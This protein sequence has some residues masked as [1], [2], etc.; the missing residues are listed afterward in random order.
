MVSF[1]QSSGFPEPFTMSVLAKGSLF[2]T[3]PTVMDYTRTR[4]ELLTCAG[5]VFSAL[6][7]GIIKVRVN[8]TYPFSATAQAQKDLQERR[9]TGSTVLIVDS[10]A[11][12]AAKV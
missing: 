6:A 7:G 10:T 2:L 8:Q 12:D 3:R 9:T 1:G 5:E 4:D 11:T